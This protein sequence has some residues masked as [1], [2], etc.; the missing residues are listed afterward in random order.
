MGLEV[1]VVD[2]FGFNLVGELKIS[3][4]ELY[5]QPAGAQFHNVRIRNAKKRSCPCVKSKVAPSVET[6]FP[7]KGSEASLQDEEKKY[8]E[9][10]S[11]VD[12]SKLE[13]GDFKE[14]PK[15]DPLEVVDVHSNRGRIVLTVSRADP[16]SQTPE[17]VSLI[18]C[19]DKLLKRDKKGSRQLIRLIRSSRSDLA[20]LDF[21]NSL[22]RLG[23]VDAAVA[24]LNNETFGPISA[25][26]LIEFLKMSNEVIET[27]GGLEYKRLIRTYLHEQGVARA[28]FML[29]RSRARKMK[30]MPSK[31]KRGQ[32]LI[33]VEHLQL[34]VCVYSANRQL[35]LNAIVDQLGIFEMIVRSC[36]SGSGD[37]EDEADTLL[38][39][40][41]LGKTLPAV[42]L[43]DFLRLRSIIPLN[44]KYWRCEALRALP[45]TLPPRL[46]YIFDPDRLACLPPEQPEMSRWERLVKS[47][48]IFVYWLFVFACFCGLLMALYSRFVATNCALTLPAL[49]LPCIIM[50]TLFYV[51]SF[52]RMVRI[53]VGSQAAVCCL[54]SI[55]CNFVGIVGLLCWEVLVL[56][57]FKSSDL[58]KCSVAFIWVNRGYLG[59]IGLLS[60]F[61]VLQ[62][63]RMQLIRAIRCI[64]FTS[65]LRRSAR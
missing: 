9:T 22:L 34:L 25:E 23:V 27:R 36:T 56:Y 31:L 46:M 28:T 19:R 5:T 47:S 17:H 49:I 51:S 30:Y 21:K 40:I 62:T 18:E 38:C 24:M 4:I 16:S 3:A 33:P 14:I 2:A 7:N 53:G 29:G 8:T 26:I 11:V 13:E 42:I 54:P 41:G 55:C 20:E 39:E 44:E 35:L 64:V 10:N 32:T 1:R 57:F 45:A 48:Q 61:S 6:L 60:L 12:V 52:A 65:C 59:F 15:F 37:K 58:E 63:I 50:T 43:N